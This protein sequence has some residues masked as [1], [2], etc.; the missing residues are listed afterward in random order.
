MTYDG[1][2]NIAQTVPPVG[3]AA[4]SLTPASCPSSYPSG[5]SNRLATD[6]TVSTYNALGQKTQQSTPA[7]GGQTGYETITYTY[8]ANGNLLTTTAPPATNGGSNQVTSDTYN[9][10][11]ATILP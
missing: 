8:D 1:D 4:G 7:P 6:A 5:Y 10:S 11:W 2:G 9:P 3:V